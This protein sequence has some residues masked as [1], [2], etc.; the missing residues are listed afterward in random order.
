MILELVNNLDKSRVQLTIND[1]QFSR[2]FIS[3][4]V[5]LPEGLSDGE[6]TYFLTDNNNILAQGLL[7]IGN[8]VQPDKT[9]YTI[10]ANTEYIQ[11]QG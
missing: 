3:G 2:L 10:S 1:P 6:Y 9:E 5:Q 4:T 8:Y 7:Q 11:Y